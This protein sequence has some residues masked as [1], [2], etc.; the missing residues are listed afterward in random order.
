ML[1]SSH[2]VHCYLFCSI[3][4]SWLS[5]CELQLTQSG[6]RVSNGE[7]LKPLAMSLTVTPRVSLGNFVFLIVTTVSELSDGRQGQPHMLLFPSG[8]PRFSDVVKGSKIV[9]SELVIS[10]CLLLLTQLQVTDM[11]QKALFDFLKHRFEGRWVFQ[12]S[13]FCGFLL[14]RW[15][16]LGGTGVWSQGESRLWS[17]WWQEE[18]SVQF[19]ELQAIFLIFAPHILSSPFSHLHPYAEPGQAPADESHPKFTISWPSMLPRNHTLCASSVHFSTL[20][21]GVH[22]ISS[23]I[24]P[25]SSRALP[26]ICFLFHWENTEETVQAIPPHIHPPLCIC[27]NAPPFLLLLW[28]MTPTWVLDPG[29]P[30]PHQHSYHSPSLSP[31]RYFSF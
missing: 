8:K 24:K 26:G 19:D 9:F 21:K 18:S 16:N 29:S 3:L 20:L 11:M 27:R 28:A 23:L 30:S 5:P 6:E 13:G 25:F 22:T 14:W 7:W 10:Y 1:F 17:L 15:W 2:G 12:N 31:R 4:F